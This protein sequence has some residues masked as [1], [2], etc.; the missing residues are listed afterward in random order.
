MAE[1][2]ITVT[3]FYLLLTVGANTTIADYRLIIIHPYSITAV[4]LA[5]LL[6]VP[7]IVCGI[8][9]IIPLDPWIALG[10]FLIAASPTGAISNYYVT[11]ARGNAAISVALCGVTSLLAF[12]T[13]PLTCW[14]IGKFLLIETLG[15]VPFSLMVKQTIPTVLL[16]VVLGIAVRHLY[17][18]W[19][20]RHQQFME[21]LSFVAIALLIIVIVV[22]RIDFLTPAIVGSAMVM[23]VLFT[24]VLSA[25]GWAIALLSAPSLGQSQ[26]SAILFGFP[27]RNLGLAALLAAKVFGI[28][29]MAAF[30]AVFFVVQ[31]FFLLP[32]ATALRHRVPSS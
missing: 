15:T 27:A 31:I 18:S 7:V 20:L 3:V 16:P 30:G 4:T 12:L 26:R 19:I 17:P 10:M 21:R 1:I 24:I 13:A 8:V 22:S 28:I 32:L 6:V 11:L 9:L 29:E 5:H 23:A 2:F 25:L 14:L